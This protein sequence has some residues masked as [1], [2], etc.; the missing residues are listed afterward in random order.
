MHV[1]ISTLPPDQ[2]VFFGALVPLQYS[3]SSRMRI[4]FGY[5]S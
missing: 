2:K 5:I 1:H 3:V 4:A